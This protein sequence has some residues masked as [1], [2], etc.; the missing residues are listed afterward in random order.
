MQMQ[1][2]GGLLVY[3]FLKSLLSRRV[4]GKIS[5][6]ACGDVVLGEGVHEAFADFGGLGELS[7][8]RWFLGISVIRLLFLRQLDQRWS[9]D[10]L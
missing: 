3:S 6:P 5:D 10:T 2:V 1:E 9:D 8:C 4:G 7:W